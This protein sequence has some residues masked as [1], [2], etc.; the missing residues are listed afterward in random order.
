MEPEGAVAGAWAVLMVLLMMSGIV[1]WIC[2]R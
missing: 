1:R 2:R